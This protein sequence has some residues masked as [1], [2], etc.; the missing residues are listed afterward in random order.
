MRAAYRPEP[1]SSSRRV[2]FDGALRAGIEAH[3]T[4]RGRLRLIVPAAAGVLAAVALWIV[5]SLPGT[6]PKPVPDL[7]IDT[8]S[9]A[10][11]E[12]GGPVIHRAWDHA[13]LIPSE[14]ED[15]L[16]GADEDAEDSLPEEY[17]AIAS[18]VFGNR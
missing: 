15:W 4:R 6:A 18:A 8:P 7:A 14:L 16:N 10:N 1:M 12:I 3:R 2:A 5:T 9:A 13:V 11:A 17:L